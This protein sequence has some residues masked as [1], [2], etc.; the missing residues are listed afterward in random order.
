MNAALLRD[1]QHAQQLLHA[2]QRFL[3]Q[4]KTCPRLI[5][6]GQTARKRV[7]EGCVNLLLQVSE[8]GVLSVKDVDTG[9]VIARST[10]GRSALD[11]GFLAP[12]R[13]L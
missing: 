5:E 6:S 7:K 9:K 3:T 10:P 2:A 12:R 8:D 4:T 1:R 13:Y 11:P